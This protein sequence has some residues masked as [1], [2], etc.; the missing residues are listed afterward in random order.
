M[1]AVTR[2]FRPTVAAVLALIVS[3]L[4]G[5]AE[6][7]TAPGPSATSGGEAEGWPSWAGPAGD[8]T[9]ASGSLA[10]TWPADGPRRLWQRLLGGG[11]S[12]ILYQGGRLFTMYRAGDEDVIVALDAKTG[13]TL[14]EQRDTP[15]YWPEMEQ[16]FGLG[17]NATP[18]LVTDRTGA[19]KVVGIGISGRMRAVD[20]R[21][22]ALAWR[23]DLPREFGRRKRVEEYG[24]SGNPLSYDGRILTLVGGDEAAVVAFDSAD[25]SA[26]WK[27]A[28]GGVSYAQPTLTRLA[29][30]E[31]YVYFEPEGVVALDPASG[32]TLWKHAIPFNNG[33]HLTPAVRC[34]ENHLWVSSQF[35]T[36]GGRLLEIQP[37]AG[38]LAVKELWFASRLRASHWPLHCRGDFLYG[39]IG[40]NG[41]STIAA[42]RWKTGEIAWQES[43]FHKAQSLWADGKL[44]FL[45]EDGRLVLAR[46]APQQFTFLAAA[47]VATPHAWTVP[48]LVGTTLFVRDKEKILAL[49]LEKR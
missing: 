21:T 20:A 39:S 13:S 18:M 16:S 33:N 9:V 35:D 44:L 30:R 32:K 19:G 40:G 17:P 22:G 25:G 14:W 3:L 42:V 29:G 23:H 10:E 7:G 43:G 6:R 45:T 37:A 38:G 4:A 34:D 24:Y 11:Y 12:S 36:G 5:A 46:V 28:P 1:H 49:D 26:V 41:S 15:G 47:K 8:F 2:L 27:S 31:Q 48:T